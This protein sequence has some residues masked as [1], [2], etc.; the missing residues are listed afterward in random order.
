MKSDDEGPVVEVG[1]PI[2]DH[3][4]MGEADLLRQVVMYGCQQRCR[5]VLV[6]R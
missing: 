5:E 3:G 4:Q 2:V 6:E 1:H